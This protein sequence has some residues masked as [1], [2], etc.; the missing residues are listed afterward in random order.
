MLQYLIDYWTR[1]PIAL[2]TN[3]FILVWF[4]VI[5]GAVVLLA[6]TAILMLSYRLPYTEYRDF[7]F[8]FFMWWP[9]FSILG[10]ILLFH[11]FWFALG[12][13]VRKFMSGKKF[14]WRR[15]GAVFYGGF[16]GSLILVI[17][18]KLRYEVSILYVLDFLF[19]VIPFFHGVSR[20]A[21]FNF[22]CCY[23][24]KCNARLLF[25]VGYR[26]SDS[27]P[28]RHGIENGQHLH[29]V[30]L[31]EMFICMLISLCLFLL[32]G[33][34]GEGKIFALYLILYGT[35]RFFLEFVR[36]N[37]HEKVFWKKISVWQMLSL[38]FVIA[39]VLLM[40]LLPVGRPMSLSR[41]PGQIDYWTIS[42]LAI[43]NAVSLGLTFGIHFRKKH[44]PL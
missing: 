10:A 40:V 44:E 32:I 41:E 12:D 7:L 11:D 8:V 28:V 18:L 23:G 4:G 3:K 37:S 27:E 35:C 20:L 22:G 5:V 26:H 13:A 19:V 14:V 42:A 31:Y 15:P 38:C 6:V 36:D 43:W 34:L 30:Q 29:A 2:R 24:K 39:G 1:T 25:S 21:C 33:R 9:F 17:L 16:T